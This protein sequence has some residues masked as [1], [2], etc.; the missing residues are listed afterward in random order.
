LD[1]DDLPNVYQQEMAYHQ[2]ERARAQTQGKRSMLAAPGTLTS[3]A[4]RAS[5]QTSLVRP[6]IEEEPV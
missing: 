4:I 6:N 1:V 5:E 3:T 2:A